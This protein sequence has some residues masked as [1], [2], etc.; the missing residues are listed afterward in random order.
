[1]KHS[2]RK[3]LKQRIREMLLTLGA[4]N[5]AVCDG[6]I[7]QATSL[8]ISSDATGAL[9]A[10]CSHK[11]VNVMSAMRAAHVYHA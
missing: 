5:C 4:T 3:T 1:M 10:Q 11:A 9:C 2:T 6:E 8:F 7:S